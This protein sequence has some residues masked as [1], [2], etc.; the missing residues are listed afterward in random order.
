MNINRVWKYKP[1]YLRK[2]NLTR[3]KSREVIKPKKHNTCWRSCDG[4]IVWWRPQWTGGGLRRVLNVDKYVDVWNSRRCAFQSREAEQL[5]E[6]M[7]GQMGQ[8]CGEEKSKRGPKLRGQCNVWRFSE[9]CGNEII[10]LVCLK[11]PLRL[12]NTK[13]KNVL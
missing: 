13:N 1:H 8:S 4:H 7:S 9:I 6:S 2:N 12:L 11:P 5:R 10:S 3:T